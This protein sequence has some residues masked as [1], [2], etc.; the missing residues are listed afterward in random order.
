MLPVSGNAD[1]L[2]DGTMVTEVALKVCHARVIGVP[3]V[4]L[5]ELAEKD[6]LG[7]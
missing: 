6:T 3:A 4:M 7:G 5:V 1:V 2:T